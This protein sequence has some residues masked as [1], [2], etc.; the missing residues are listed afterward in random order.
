MEVAKKVLKEPNNIA[1]AGFET[2][3]L[4]SMKI[5]QESQSVHH[6]A[7]DCGHATGQL[8]VVYQDT[9]ESIA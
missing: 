2:C 9:A 1:A 6:T 4:V 7:V 3:T 8:F 5:V